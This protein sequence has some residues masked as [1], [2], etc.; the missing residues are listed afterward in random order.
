MELEGS[1]NSATGG[2]ARHPEPLTVI[3]DNS[4]AHRGDALRTYLATPGLNLRLVNL[5]SYSPDFNALIFD[6]SRHLGLG[7]SGDDRHGTSSRVQDRQSA[8]TANPTRER[9]EEARSAYL[10]SFA[11]VEP[12]LAGGRFPVLAESEQRPSIRPSSGYAPPVLWLE[13]RLGIPKTRE[14]IYW[15]VAR[16]QAGYSVIVYDRFWLTGYLWKSST[17]LEVKLHDMNPSLN[18][19][20]PHR[21]LRV[22][23]NVWS[24]TSQ[25]GDSVR[26]R[27]NRSRPRSRSG[28]RQRIGLRVGVSL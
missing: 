19:F 4:P 18:F 14:M 20:A 28:Q 1:S 3:W 26:S 16:N 2:R 9:R 11:S 24:R 21:W 17:V 22:G 10:Q 12:Q 6:Q 15:I 23:S 13:L 8:R 27:Q 7:T 25:P 5:P